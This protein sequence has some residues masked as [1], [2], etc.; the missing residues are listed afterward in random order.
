MHH[1]VRW[2]HCKVMRKMSDWLTISWMGTITLQE[3][4]TYGSLPS[5]LIWIGF[6][7]TNRTRL[8]LNS[9]SR[10]GYRRLIFT[11]TQ[12]LRR[13]VFVRL[14]FMLTILWFTGYWYI[15]VRDTL[16]SLMM[17]NQHTRPLILRRIPQFW[18]LFNMRGITKTISSKRSDW[19]MKKRW[20][21]KLVWWWGKIIIRDR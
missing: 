13:E 16:E 3:I 8:L 10:E 14:R 9:T 2:L 4:G 1:R 15:K 21:G 6:R 12:K 19:L 7:R 5:N 20:S 18:S 17:S 11:T